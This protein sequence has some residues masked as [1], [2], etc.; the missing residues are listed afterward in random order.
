MRQALEA[1][2]MPLNKYTLNVLL[3]SAGN[4]KNPQLVLEYWN[5]LLKVRN[6]R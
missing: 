3:N 6:L 4:T 2:G 5:V 1:Q